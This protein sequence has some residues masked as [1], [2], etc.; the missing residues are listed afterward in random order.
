MTQHTLTFNLPTGVSL[1][2]LILNDKGSWEA[3]C[4]YWTEPDRYGVAIP[5]QFGYAHKQHKAEKAIE[6]A[7]QDAW[8]KFRAIRNKRNSRPAPGAKPLTEEEELLKLLDL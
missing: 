1:A 4:C 6:L 5:T 3:V 7:G 2:R 8:D